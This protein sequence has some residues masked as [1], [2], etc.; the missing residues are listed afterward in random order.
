V[1]GRRASLSRGVGR[2]PSERPSDVGRGIRT[3]R[4]EEDVDF[5]RHVKCPCVTGVRARGGPAIAV[6]RK[7]GGPLPPTLVQQIRWRLRRR[8]G[9]LA[10]A[11]GCGE[12]GPGRFH[13]D[14]PS[15]ADRLHHP[16]A[17]APRHTP[18]SVSEVESQRGDR[19]SY[20]AASWT[21]SARVRSSPARYDGQRLLTS[22]H[23]LSGSSRDLGMARKTDARMC[24]PADVVNA[25]LAVA[26][27]CELRY[28]SVGRDQSGGI[29]FATT[30]AFSTIR[31]QTCQH[32][33]ANPRCRSRP[34]SSRRLWR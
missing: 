8:S 21:R 10:S 34:L 13:A 14:A 7:T 29:K 20:T 16:V 9:A 32:R 18:C 3:K 33:A 5:R 22:A 31:H 27:Q 12:I 2:Q 6:A 17:R 26:G 1:A 25:S 19:A 28:R 15:A 30:W 4:S 24:P 23:R 11:S